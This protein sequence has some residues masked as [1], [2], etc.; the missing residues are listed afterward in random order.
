MHPYLQIREVLTDLKAPEEA[1][2]IPRHHWRTEST[3]L[4]MPTDCICGT[5]S[6]YK[7]TGGPSQMNSQVSRVSLSISYSVRA[8]R[9]QVVTDLHRHFQKHLSSLYGLLV[10][11]HALI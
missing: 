9:P 3:H 2:V 11:N 10:S 7:D 1:S 5:L 8:S 4:I 6:S